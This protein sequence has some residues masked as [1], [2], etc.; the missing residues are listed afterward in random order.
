MVASLA[1]NFAFVDAKWN[2]ECYAA[3]PSE[4]ICDLKFIEA[5]DETNSGKVV[6]AAEFPNVIKIESKNRVGFI[7]SNLLTT[8][9][10]VRF[11]TIETFAPAV[12]RDLFLGGE[13]VEFL[14]ITSNVETLICEP[15]S[16]LR[17]LLTLK[18]KSEIS[19]LD[20]EALKCLPKLERLD[21]S[22]NKLRSID[23]KMF[24]GAQALKT[25]F[26]Q[27]NQIQSIESGSFDLPSLEVIN[28]NSNK[29]S[30][31]EFNLFTQAPNLVEISL[32]RNLLKIIDFELPES[33]EEFK[34]SNNPI[35]SPIDVAR[36]VSSLPEIKRLDLE[37]TTTSITFTESLETTRVLSHINLS[38]NKLTDA[39]IL[40][41]LKIFP[42]LE[43][44]DLEGNEFKTIKGLRDAKEIFSK[45]R[46][47][48]IK[49]NSFECNWLEPEISPLDVE[50]DTIR[51]NRIGQCFKS[52]MIKQKIK[53]VECA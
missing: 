31:I 9:P 4:G 34:I 41:R 5:H 37:N 3:D 38:Y 46:Q 49:C 44:I 26:L 23:S 22:E 13:N 43:I 28:L 24:S 17:N 32:E 19:S 39:D 40:E 7:P 30:S 2:Y 42:N 36:L 50:F 11:L 25:L 35:E 16:P 8:F 51:V 1:I 27:N 53:D 29:L 21:L 18:L 20:K 15:F 45:L 12:S 14:T 47:L 33:L 48:R 6:N 10:L 52:G